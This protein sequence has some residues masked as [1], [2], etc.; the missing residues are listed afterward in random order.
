MNFATH[1]FVTIA[2]L[3]IFQ[4]LVFANFVALKTKYRKIDNSKVKVLN[5]YQNGISN[6]NAQLLIMDV[7]K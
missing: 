1:L 4:N 7:S 2:I 6:P 5:F 3:S